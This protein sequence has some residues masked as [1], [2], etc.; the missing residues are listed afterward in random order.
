MNLDD[1]VK[2]PDPAVGLVECLL[3]GECLGSVD[4]SDMPIKALQQIE[5]ELLDARYA[6]VGNLHN[7]LKIA[8]GLAVLD[9]EVSRRIFPSSGDNFNT[10]GKV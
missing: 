8:R 1:I 9:A 5:R 7:M 2:T 4:L 3:G 6:S 10:I